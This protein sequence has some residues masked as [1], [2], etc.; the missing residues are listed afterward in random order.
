MG[1][2]GGG[3]MGSLTGY[4]VAHSVR[5]STTQYNPNL[6]STIKPNSPALVA[7]SN[8]TLK[9]D[10][11]VIDAVKKVQPA[12]VTVVNQMQPQRG[13]RG[14]TVSPT[15]SGSGVIIDA[16]GDIVTNNHVIE[17]SQKLQVIFADETKA[18]AKLVGTDTVLDIAVLRVVGKMPAVA[19]FG[20]SSALEPGQVAIAI[21]SPLGD[22]RGT[23]TVGVISA[24]NRTVETETGLIQT[25]AAINNGNSGGPL[26]DSLGQVI[27]IN[28]LAVRSSGSGN[29]AEGLGFAIPSDLVKDIAAQLIA[30]GSVQHPYLG[31]AYQQVDPQIASQLNLNTTNGI[32]VTQID[33]SGP[34]EKAGLQEGDVILTING[35]T[36]D[37]DHVL[38][39]M[40][41]THKPGETLNLTVLRNGQQL[42]TNVTL[43][44]YPTS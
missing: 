3:L 10:S 16:N 43:A 25:D 32:L 14:S 38:A 6:V 39:G 17:N 44:L 12:V 7:D 13:A 36:I 18:D 1:V 29:V 41:L 8:V 15:A 35:Q 23:V 4:Y 24:L 26:I 11:A 34:A 31:L 30:T 2:I 27:G 20:N 5:P 22:F 40:L 21:G 19:Q 28:T 42:K 9:E 37:P 33:P